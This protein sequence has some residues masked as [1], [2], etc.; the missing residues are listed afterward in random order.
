MPDQS[1]RKKIGIGTDPENPRDL[2][3]KIEFQIGDEMHVFDKTTVIFIPKGLGHGPFMH[4]RVER[5]SSVTDMTNDDW[6]HTMDANLNSMMQMARHCIPLMIE[7]GGGSIVHVAS[8]STMAEPVEI[9]KCFEFLASD[10]SSFV[11]GT[12][13]VADGR[14]SAVD[15]G[16][17]SLQ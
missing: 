5:E 12:T 1:N 10:A 4:K 15:V 17:I 8:L 14:S 16:Y 6:N 9:A 3:G 13:L 11:T 7:N 2:G